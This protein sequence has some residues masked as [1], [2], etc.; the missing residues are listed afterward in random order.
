MEGE[1]WP[2]EASSSAIVE[3]AVQ[4]GKRE[5]IEWTW[6]RFAS[7]DAASLASVLFREAASA[8]EMNLL[9]WARSQGMED[10]EAKVTFHA[11]AEGNPVMLKWAHEEQL[12]WHPETCYKL[13]YHNRVDL[14]KWA[15]SVGCPWG[16]NPLRGSGEIE[17]GYAWAIRHGAPPLGGDDV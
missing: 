13:V 8:G 6:Q 3:V 2:V 9:K 17:A 5:V 7:T 16:P 11:A 4:C 10:V 12:P 1:G 15:H 14:L